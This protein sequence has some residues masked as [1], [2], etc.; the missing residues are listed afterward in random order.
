MTPKGRYTKNRFQRYLAVRLPLLK[1][2]SYDYRTRLWTRCLIRPTRRTR[3]ES[4]NLS[5][6]RKGLINPSTRWILCIGRLG[7]NFSKRASAEW[8]DALFK[9]KIPQS[10]I[11]KCSHRRRLYLKKAKVNQQRLILYQRRRKGRMR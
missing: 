2:H 7:R 1:S 6:T 8:L 11:I 4:E 9:L 3:V 10:I 5:K